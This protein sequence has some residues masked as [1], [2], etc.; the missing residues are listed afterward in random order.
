MG[1][2]IGAPIQFAIAEACLPLYQGN[3]IR[4]ALGL[5]FE[6]LVHTPL[7][8]IG[9]PRGIPPLQQGP[10]SLSQ[11]GDVCHPLVGLLHQGLQGLLPMHQHPLDSRWLKQ[12]AIVFQGGLNALLA[13]GYPQGQIKLGDVQFRVFPLQ[14][15]PLPALLRQHLLLPG[16][17]DLE[18]RRA[19]Q[20]PLGLQSLHH[21]LKGHLLMAVGPQGH[22]AHMGQQLAETGWPLQ[23]AAQD[24]RVDEEA[25]QAFQLG[26]HA[27]GNRGAYRDVALA[28]VALQDEQPA[29]QQRH[30]QR[31]PFLATEGLQLLL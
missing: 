20:L 12:V 16:K 28:A 25:D 23:L 2:L 27:V 30:E 4:L 31:H 7:L 21:T 15:D 3:A 5:L 1:Q 13:L 14:G 6:Q 17:H 8:R 18:E 22:L 19:V 29:G 26:L 11:E 24:Q 9:S 10:L